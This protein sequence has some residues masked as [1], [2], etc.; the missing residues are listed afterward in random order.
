MTTALH[1]FIKLMVP[2]KIS[3]FLRLHKYNDLTLVKRSWKLISE[4]P[5][6]LLKL[7]YVAR[8]NVTHI[9]IFQSI[10]VNKKLDRIL[11]GF[12]M[13]IMASYKKTNKIS[14]KVTHSTDLV[15]KPDPSRS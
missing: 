15:V 12:S 9:L 13:C 4:G 7:Y 10:I 5:F 14:R 2:F 6:L 8:V 11:N 3:L 1:D